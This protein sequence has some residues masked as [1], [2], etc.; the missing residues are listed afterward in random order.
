MTANSLSCILNHQKGNYV[1]LIV[2]SFT[3]NVLDQRSLLVTMIYTS[4]GCLPVWLQF[5]S[6]QCGKLTHK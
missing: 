4:G 3:L 5:E 2:G 6:L 1:F